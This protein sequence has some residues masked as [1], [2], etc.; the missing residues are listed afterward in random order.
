MLLIIDDDPLFHYFGIGGFEIHVVEVTAIAVVSCFDRFTCKIQNLE[1]L[2]G[3]FLDASAM[4][5]L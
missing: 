1:K 2:F 4:P 5:H 3:F